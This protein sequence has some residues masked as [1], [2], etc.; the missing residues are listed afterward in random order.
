MDIDTLRTHYKAKILDA[1]KRNKLE[2]VRVFGSTARGDTS[3]TSDVDFLVHASEDA[4]L[5]DL[6]GF[7]Y[8]VE[9]LLGMKVDV[10]TDTSLHWYIKERVLREAVML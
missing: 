5:M 2:S 1:A 4:S 6:G 7:S 8:E 10:V 9:T 3:E